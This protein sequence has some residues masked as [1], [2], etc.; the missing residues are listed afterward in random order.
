MAREPKDVRTVALVGHTGSGKTMLAEAMLLACGE[1]K[2]PGRIESGTTV[3]DFAPEEKEAARS[4]NLG[5]LHGA[6]KGR[7]IQVLDAPGYADF[8]GQAVA[9]LSAAETAL[10][11]VNAVNGIEVTT[12]KVWELAGSAGCS[13]MFVI[14]RL[15]GENAEFDEVLESLRSTFGAACAPVSVPRGTGRALEGVVD[16]LHPEG[17]LP[18]GADAMRQSL[19][20][21]AISADDALLEKYLEGEEV[22]PEALEGVMRLAILSGELVPVFSVASEKGMG[23]AGLLDFVASYAP[24]PLDA[25]PA[26]ESGEGALDPSADGAFAARVFKVMSDDYVGKV[27]FFRVYRGSLRAGETVHLP[28]GETAKIPK[29][30]RFQGKEQEEVTS[31]GTGDIAATA[32]VEALSFGASIWGEPDGPGIA[33]PSTPKP[34]VERAVEP[35]TRGDEGKISEALRKLADED[36]TFDWRQDPQTKETVVAAMG[37]RHLKIMLDRMKRR[38]GLEVTT[39]PPR[40]AYRETVTQP[41]DVRYRHKKQ[42]GGAGQFAECAIKVEPAARGEGYEF[43]DEIFGGAID[44]QFRPSVDKGVRQKMAEG[45]IAG[46][47]VVDLKVRLYDGKTHPVDSKD[48][49]FQIA[50]REAAKEAVLKAKPVLLEPIVNMEIAIPARFLGDVTGDISGRRGRIQ[51]MDTLGEMQVVKASVPA[52]E[53][54]TYS[55]ELQSLTGGEGFFTMEFSRYDVVPSNIAQQVIA[56]QSKKKEEE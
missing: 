30:Y 8:V 6:W 45:V 16:L 1:L 55:T 9:A 2:E 7:E 21:S 37:D 42:T 35:K 13:R 24:T 10:I 18:E 41:A 11:T 46:F 22:P 43:I 32:K 44:Q 14:T 4:V 23:V 39:R 3:S 36:P 25:R 20:E 28:D 26:L 49:A 51:G 15:D 29:L 40:I 38:F 48:I 33:R 47:P 17:E 54:Q 56:Q 5:V 34:M 19:M 52:A 27:S 50:G 12:R 53:V 31:C